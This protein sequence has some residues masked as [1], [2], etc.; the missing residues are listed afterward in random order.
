M[1]FRSV[2]F[3][4]FMLNSGIGGSYGDSGTSLV[5]QKVKSPPAVQETWVLSLG[6]EDPLEEGMT[7]HSSVLAEESH[8][9]RTANS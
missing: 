7:T 1:S 8:G 3:S 6:W 5:A 2:A 9:Q 4:R